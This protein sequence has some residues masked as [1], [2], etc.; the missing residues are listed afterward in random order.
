[1]TFVMESEVRQGNIGGGHKMKEIT[2]E[3]TRLQ[4]LEIWLWRRI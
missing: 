4:T 2:E 1:M 3:I